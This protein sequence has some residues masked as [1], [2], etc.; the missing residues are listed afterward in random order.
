MA[1]SNLI[2]HE[3][4]WI[5]RMVDR[6]RTVEPVPPGSTCSRFLLHAT[7]LLSTA[8]FLNQYSH[9][10]QPREGRSERPALL[11]FEPY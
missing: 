10:Q 2:L 8:S 11:F 4:N 6:E 9:L 1:L 3:G 5:G 7:S